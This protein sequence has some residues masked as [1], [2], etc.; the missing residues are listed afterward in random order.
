M[1][2]AGLTAA[3]A[4]GAALS[5]V[6]TTGLHQKFT[7]TGLREDRDRGLA[8]QRRTNVVWG[9]TAAAAA[10]TAVIGV[11][12]TDW[13]GSSAISVGTSGVSAHFTWDTPR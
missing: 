8:A 7:E 1:A 11:F 3:L 10:A 5:A 9:A 6:D 4:G 13:T 2:G 12:F